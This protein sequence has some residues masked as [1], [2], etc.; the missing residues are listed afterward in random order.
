[1]EIHELEY[2]LSRV[3][4]AQDNRTSKAAFFVYF[5]DSVEASR[6]G[7]VFLKVFCSFVVDSLVGL[8]VINVPLNA[9]V[10]YSPWARA[11]FLTIQRDKL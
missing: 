2:T 9:F 10:G 4:I 5:R 1:M 8:L 11:D 3:S 7:C 6:F